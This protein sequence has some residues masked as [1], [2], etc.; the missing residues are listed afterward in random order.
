[1]EAFLEDAVNH[2]PK[3]DADTIKLN[4]DT[5]I[6]TERLQSAYRSHA[7]TVP[8]CAETLIPDLRW[9]KAFAKDLHHH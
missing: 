4:K 3:R 6:V 7:H 5:T 2:A 9:L 8:A 1:M